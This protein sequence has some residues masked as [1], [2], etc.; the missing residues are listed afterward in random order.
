LGREANPTVSSFL[1]GTDDLQ[2]DS[3]KEVT[4]LG[5]DIK[6]RRRKKAG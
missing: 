4:N 5:K 3:I 2:I 1:T 6:K